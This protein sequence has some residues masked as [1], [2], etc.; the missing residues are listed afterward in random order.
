MEKNDGIAYT[1]AKATSCIEKAKDALSVFEASKIKDTLFDIADYA[2]A[3]R[4]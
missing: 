1:I 4:I 2:L 3:R